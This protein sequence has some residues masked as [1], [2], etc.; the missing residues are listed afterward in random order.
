[1]ATF[2]KCGNSST[3][4]NAAIYT[5]NAALDMGYSRT[6]KTQLHMNNL[7]R[8]FKKRGFIPSVAMFLKT[9]M[10]G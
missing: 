8:V 5:K 6:Y 4:K 7:S 1:M 2:F 3:P 9:K 10:A